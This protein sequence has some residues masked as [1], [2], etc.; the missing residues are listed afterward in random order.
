MNENKCN[1]Y[2]LKINKLIKSIDNNLKEDIFNI[3]K[4]H[5]FSKNRTNS[6]E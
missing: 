4:F 3:P 5:T 1:E 2:L 6:S